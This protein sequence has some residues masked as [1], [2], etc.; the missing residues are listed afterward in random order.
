MPMP[1]VPHG[2]GRQIRHGNGQTASTLRDGM[3]D[4]QQ[5]IGGAH[6]APRRPAAPPILASLIPL[7]AG[8]QMN[9]EEISARRVPLPRTRGE[10]ENDFIIMRAMQ[11][12]FQAA[13]ARLANLEGPEAFPGL[14]EP[15]ARA[16][17]E[18]KERVF[19]SNDGRAA[20]SIFE[21]ASRRY[22]I[23]TSHEL[24]RQ[25]IILS[26]SDQI[27]LYRHQTN[28]M[29]LF[30]ADFMA[31]QGSLPPQTPAFTWN[32]NTLMADDD[33][34]FAEA[35]EYLTLQ[36]TPNETH[37]GLRS[38]AIQFW[39]ELWSGTTQV[40]DV[41]IELDASASTL[42]T[43]A[44]TLDAVEIPADFG[45]MRSVLAMFT[46]SADFAGFAQETLDSEAATRSFEIFEHAH[47]RALQNGNIHPYGLDFLDFEVCALEKYRDQLVRWLQ[48]KLVANAQLKAAQKEQTRSIAPM[49]GVPQEKVHSN[50]SAPTYNWA[51]RF[52][53][54]ETSTTVPRNAIQFWGE[55]LVWYGSPGEAVPARVLDIT[56]AE[57]PVRH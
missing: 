49:D 31:A 21:R 50:R 14:R 37:L 34:P 53:G 54:Q 5:E 19:G 35:E 26:I 10:I 51:L 39:G 40:F 30:R 28:L 3:H 2:Q 43:I 27:D 11:N 56:S 1:N 32:E 17:T 33:W 18:L 6:Q 9:H 42:D 38:S 25:G 47:A 16:L 20:F 4:T 45:L 12:L 7:E 41:K 23:N 57:G 48:Q 55:L 13:Q 46:E 24:N 52:D 8:E 22:S 36:F 44:A 29:H 15:Q